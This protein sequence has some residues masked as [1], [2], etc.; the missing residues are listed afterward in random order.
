MNISIIGANSFLAK[1]LISYL[2]IEGKYKIQAYCRN[3]MGD[4]KRYAYPDWGVEKISIEELL[5]SDIIIYAAGAGVQPNHGESEDIIQELNANEPI[6]L[7][8]RLNDHN[9]L[10]KMITF[11]SYFEIGIS[12][13]HQAYTESMIASNDNPLPNVYCSSKRTLTKF[14]AKQ[15]GS[16]SHNHLHLILTNI[17]GMGE[18]QHRLLPYLAQSIKNKIEIKLT[19]GDQVRQYTHISDVVNIIVKS[20]NNSFSGILNFTA[21]TCLSIQE[22][23]IKFA[24]LTN[25]PIDKLI[26]N[27]V[28]KRDVNMNH[29]SLNI[30]KLLS[31]HQDQ[32]FTPLETGL[33]S[34]LKSD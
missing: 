21:P 11:G 12:A 19:S 15:L 25:Y 3:N 7:I 13:E 5:K 10:G 24:S 28:Q 18:N 9:Y 1:N 8:K 32:K 22:L 30:S 26:F 27:S 23:V 31:I 6:R 17:Y 2:N 4:Q 29:L 14:I 33:K 34:Y 16:F 20:F